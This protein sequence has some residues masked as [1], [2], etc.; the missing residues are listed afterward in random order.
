M[1]T[2]VGDGTWDWPERQWFRANMISTVDGS[3]QGPD[4]LSGSI[5]NAVDRAV[6]QHLRATADVILVGAGTARAEGYG[7][8][9]TPIVVVSRSQELPEALR[10]GS[11]VRLAAGGAPE[12]LREMVQGLHAEGLCRVLCEGGPRLLR[13]LLE[14]GVVDELCATVVPRLVAGDGHRMVAGPPLDVDL[15]L[16][17]LVEEEGTLLA[18]WRV[19]R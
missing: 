9:D 4:G 14:A 12:H 16:A 11:N 7:P 5:N 1:K 15:D 18:R 2:L 6:F 19:R 13:D 8:V 17:M 10:G 3:I